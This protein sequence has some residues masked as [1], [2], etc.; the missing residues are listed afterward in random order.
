MSVAKKIKENKN[1]SPKMGLLV[2][3]QFISRSDILGV[4]TLVNSAKNTLASRGSS[5][6]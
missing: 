6:R 2:E 4:M 5:I 3:N 1:N